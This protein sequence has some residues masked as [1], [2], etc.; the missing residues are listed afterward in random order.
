MNECSKC[1]GGTF[2]SETGNCD[3]QSDK[4]YFVMSGGGASPPA[5]ATCTACKGDEVINTARNGCECSTG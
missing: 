4:F 5:T 3:C 2:N 1:V